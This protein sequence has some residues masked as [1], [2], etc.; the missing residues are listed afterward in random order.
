M[1]YFVCPKCKYKISNIEWKKT[2]TNNTC[3]NCKKQ[4]LTELKKK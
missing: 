4:I 3:P 2:K 1:M